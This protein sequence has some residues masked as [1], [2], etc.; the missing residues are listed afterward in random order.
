MRIRILIQ[1]QL[2]HHHQQIRLGEHS[3]AYS[4]FNF[5]KQLQAY[6][7]LSLIFTQAENNKAMFQIRIGFN[8]DPEPDQDPAF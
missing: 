7:N 1:I 5:G 6:S 4:K 8:A 2:R 3:A